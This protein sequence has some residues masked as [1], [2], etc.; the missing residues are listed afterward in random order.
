LSKKLKYKISRHK[1][2]LNYLCGKK[3]MVLMTGQSLAAD[4]A[5]TSFCINSLRHARVLS[6][7]K[8][9]KGTHPNEGLHN[10]QDDL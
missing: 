3:L 9:R 7:P 1:I 2:K 6:Q 10:L 5:R 4:A 8:M